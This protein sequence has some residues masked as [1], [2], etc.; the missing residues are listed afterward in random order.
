MRV[1][2]V[3]APANGCNS[4]LDHF[5]WLEEVVDRAPFI[6]LTPRSILIIVRHLPSHN[7]SDWKILSELDLAVNQQAWA[8][9]E[10]EE[11]RRPG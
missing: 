8:Y 5:S 2:E 3:A 11:F 4:T 10:A 1:Y 7:P 9:G 6:R